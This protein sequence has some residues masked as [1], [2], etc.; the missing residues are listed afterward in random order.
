MHVSAPRAFV[1]G[2]AE[3]VE[4]GDTHAETGDTPD[5]CGESVANPL[6][7]LGDGYLAALILGDGTGVPSRRGLVA[8]VGCPVCCETQF[9]CS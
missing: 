2:A 9:C 3:G 4:T 5:P 1:D 7:I 8:S 6:Y